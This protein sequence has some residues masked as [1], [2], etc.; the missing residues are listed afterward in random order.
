[1]QT[2][3]QTRLESERSGPHEQ[4]RSRSEAK[5]PRRE[6]HAQARS[7]SGLKKP[8]AQPRSQGPPEQKRT[9]AGVPADETRRAAKTRPGL[10]KRKTKSRLP[11]LL[12]L[13]QRRGRGRGRKGKK[14]GRGQDAAWRQDACDGLYGIFDSPGRRGLG[15]KLYVHLMKLM[16]LEHMILPGRREGKMQPRGGK[17]A[18]ART[19]DSNKK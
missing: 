17:K 7:Q 6:S 18:V 9:E 5:D 19:G 14:R 4:T 11:T 15:R 10:K 12:G 1:M 2:R 13:A 8:R 16:G 3:S